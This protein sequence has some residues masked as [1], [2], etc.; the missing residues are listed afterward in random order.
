M[1][2]KPFGGRGKGNRDRE[3][4]IIREEKGRS[5][6]DDFR[7]VERSQSGGGGGGGGQMDKMTMRLL[8]LY[9]EKKWNGQT[10]ML[11]LSGLGKAEVP[12][13]RTLYHLHHPHTL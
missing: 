3:V 9:C 1:G 2:R 10:G 13:V 4:I 5:D 7:K 8:N 6:R 11:D 12:V